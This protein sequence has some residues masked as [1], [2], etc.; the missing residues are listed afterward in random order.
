MYKPSSYK[1]APAS[2]RIE[3]Y[4]CSVK[5]KLLLVPRK[6]PL[7]KKRR[8]LN[9]VSQ[10]ALFR[11]KIKQVCKRLLADDDII[12]RETDKKLGLCVIPRNWYETQALSILNNHLNYVH[13]PVES[14]PTIKKA[15]SDLLCAVSEH[16][17]TIDEKVLAFVTQMNVIDE[18]PAKCNQLDFIP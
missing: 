2:R 14:I 18:D 11:S 3:S 5:R 17:L 12:V 6:V 8:S 4:L 7:T 10:F 1:F 16:E 13:V 15:F 9:V